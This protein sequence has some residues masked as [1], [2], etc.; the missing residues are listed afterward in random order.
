V[1]AA[2]LFMVD[3]A[4]TPQTTMLRFNERVWVSPPGV[5]ALVAASARNRRTLPAF[6]LHCG[7]SFTA[8]RMTKATLPPRGC[9]HIAP[10]ASPVAG[11]ISTI[12]L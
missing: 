12:K 8:A 11:G 5:L 7:Y 10:G 3:D 4:R 9:R 1:K 2:R 6:A